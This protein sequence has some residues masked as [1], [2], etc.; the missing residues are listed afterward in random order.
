[1]LV[2]LFA[3]L[4]MVG[5]GLLAWTDHSARKAVEQYPPL[6]RFVEA[7][8]VRLHYLDRGEGRPVVL[9][10]GASGNLRDWTQSIFDA[11]AASHRA[12][13]FDRPGH[14]HSARPDEAGW[15]P[16]VQAR[17][18]RAA[19]ASIG[20][21]KP[22]LVGH[23]WAGTVALAYA[24]DYPDE[25]GGVLFL[26]GVS[27]P[28]PGGVGADRA[29]ATTPVLGALF[30]NTLVM[31]VGRAVAGRAIEGVFAPNPVP[32]GYAE[33]LGL[34]LVLRPES[35]RANA[36][37]LTNLKP[38]VAEMSERYGEIRVPVTLLAGAEDKVIWNSLHADALAREIEGARHVVLDGIGHMPHHAAPAAVLAEIDALAARVR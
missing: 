15:D 10:H 36:E 19:L 2:T 1:M 35:Y 5:G 8:G 21:E 31:P 27:H 16:R 18:V 34:P 23:S 22:I 30:T 3:A 4:A 32:P 38:I 14:G 11:V 33:G 6:G 9:L 13:A 26:A 25:V 28:W 12:I 37:D 20:V 7:G 29:I 17:L 24:L